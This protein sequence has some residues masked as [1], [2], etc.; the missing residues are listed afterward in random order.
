MP[1]SMRKAT[2]AIREMFSMHNW[3]YAYNEEQDK[4]TARFNLSKTRLGN[5][6]I[7]I[8]P[9]PSSADPNVCRAIVAYGRIRLRATPETMAPICEYL[10]RANLGLSIGNFELDH[11]DGE[12]RYKVSMNCRDAIPSP[13]A[14]EDVI[15]IP[16]AM[17]NRYGDCLLAVSE[18]TLSAE[19][20]AKRADNI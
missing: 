11:R 2:E 15:D 8:R 13:H 20:A 1:V 12:I 4:F 5:V 14:M 17:Y 9:R 18:G 19:E 16:V 6:E 10:T 3:A 7:Q